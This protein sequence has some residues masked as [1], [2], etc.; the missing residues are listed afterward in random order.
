VV[1]IVNE[2]DTVAT[3][4]IRFG[5][6][7]NLSATIV[8]LVAADLLVILTDVDGLYTE[9]PIA[10]KPKPALYHVIDEITQEIEH[11]AQGSASAFGRGGMTTKLEAAGSA[12]RS[13]A[14]TVLC[15]GRTRDALLRVAA[16]ESLGTLFAPGSKLDGHKHWLAF[17][18]RTRGALVVDEDAAKAL[19]QR[20]KSLLPAGIVE[21]RGKFAVGDPVACEDPSGTEFARGLVGYDAD[22]IRRI[23]GSPTRDLLTVLGYSNGSEVI[24]RDDLVLLDSENHSAGTHPDGKLGEGLGKELGKNPERSS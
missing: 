5:D 19:I 15:N 14:A 12:S 1:P 9:Q 11:A 18:R 17:T 4:E 10:G 7:D 6:N 16:G 13:G 2:N 8:N 24:H 20:G 22:A 23:A 21:V 3:E